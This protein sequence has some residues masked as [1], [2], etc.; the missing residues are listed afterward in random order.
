MPTNHKV[1]VAWQIVFTFIPIADLWAY[2]RIKKLGK[3]LLYIY[4]PTSIISGVY[5][6]SII[7]AIFSDPNF[8]SRNDPTFIYNSPLY[9]VTIGLSWALHGFA[10]Y[11]IIIWSRQHNKQFD[12]P[13]SQSAAPAA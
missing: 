3:Y 1:S 8:A 10:I 9:F 11:L 12:Q 13:T 2:Y 4:L 5:L 6:T 7:S